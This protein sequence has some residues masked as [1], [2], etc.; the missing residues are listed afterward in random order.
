MPS[1]GLRVVVAKIQPW[2][3]PQLHPIEQFMAQN[4]GS[5]SQESFSRIDII[6]IADDRK[7]YVGVV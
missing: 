5:F 6:P 7:V 4:G 3:M 1:A 2:G